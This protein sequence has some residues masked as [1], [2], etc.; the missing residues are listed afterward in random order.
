[1]AQLTAAERAAL[2]GEVQ[3]LARRLATQV[4]APRPARRRG[5]LD[6]RA[7]LRASHGTGGVPFDVRRRHRPR[8]RPRLV[9]LCDVSDSVRPVSRFLLTLVHALT[10]RYDRVHTF[11]FVADL[12]DATRLFRGHDVER[13]IAAIAAGAVIDPWQSSD[14][15]RTLDQLAARHLGKIGARTTVVILGDGRGNRR[16]PRAA[17]L[18]DVHRRA[19]RVVWLD[20][21]PPSAWGWGDSAMAAYAPH[22][23]HVLTVANLASLRAAIDALAGLAPARGARRGSA[24]GAR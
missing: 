23:D 12:G 18:A 3:R 4:P 8:R 1:M 16:P 11:V 13:A 14:Y 10:R 17:V 5:R 9:V 15:G 7:T 24:R 22:C 21:E 20:P 2:D 6:V 19:H